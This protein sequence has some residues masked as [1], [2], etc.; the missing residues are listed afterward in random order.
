MTSIPRAFCILFVLLTLAS[1]GHDYWRYREVGGEFSFSQVG[2][3]IQLYAK[4]EHDEARTVIADEIG[5]EGF[6]AVFVPVL[7]SYTAALTGGLA[8]LFAVIGLL[9]GYKKHG[10]LRGGKPRNNMR[11]RR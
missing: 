2:G 11:F 3:L 4:D 6:N 8:L 1:I 5:A 7:K 10:D 9:R